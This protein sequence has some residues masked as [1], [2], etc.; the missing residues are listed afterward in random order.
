MWLCTVRKSCDYPLHVEKESS[1]TMKIKSIAI[2]TV[3]WPGL[4]GEL[5][6]KILNLIVSSC[7]HALHV[8]LILPS[9]NLIYGY[10][11]HVH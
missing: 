9:E 10:Y 8:T 5:T 11:V 2:K 1:G 6:D 3:W 7:M 4:N